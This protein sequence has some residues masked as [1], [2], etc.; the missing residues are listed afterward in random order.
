VS[1]HRVKL[2]VAREANCYYLAMMM[3]TPC[4][5]P[6][7]THASLVHTKSGLC[8]WKIHRH[9]HTIRRRASCKHTSR[10]ITAIISFPLIVSAARASGPCFLCAVITRPQSRYQLVP[11]SFACCCVRDSTTVKLSGDLF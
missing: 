9:R 10:L 2:R 1:L 4:A 3:M 5:R 11:L 6:A 7:N 8:V